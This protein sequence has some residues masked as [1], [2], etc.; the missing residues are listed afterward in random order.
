MTRDK[1]FSKLK[2]N[3][4]TGCLEWQGARSEPYGMIRTAGVKQL[5]HRVAA[6]YA[7]LIPSIR[8]ENGNMGNDLVLHR[9]DN[10]ICCN[11]EHLFVGN[12]ADNQADKVTKRRQ[13]R[14]EAQGKSVL[15][16]LQVTTLRAAV[17]RG[18]EH[19]VCAKVLGVSDSTI[20]FAVN[21]S[22]WGWLDGKPDPDLLRQLHDAQVA[23]APVKVAKGERHGRSKLTDAQVAEMR[24]LRAA[25]I[26]G[27]GELA[28]KYGI[29]REQA[30][31]ILNFRVRKP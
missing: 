4:V 2:L 20:T 24:M 29:G 21:G 10:P 25:G 3:P 17:A 12:H 16:E 23:K 14:G 8:G 27:V 18:V 9:C 15:T 19:R 7:G 1:F 28:C 13:A 31:A 5:A 6:Y 11:P 22:S 26:Y 30:S